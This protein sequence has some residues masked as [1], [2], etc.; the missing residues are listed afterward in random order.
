M[1]LSENAL[2]VLKARYLLKDENGEV[3]ESPTE[4]FRRVARSIAKMEKAYGEDARYWE[5]QFYDLMS[6]LRF[7]PNSPA[8]MNAGKSIGQLAACFALPVEDSM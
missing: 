1:E 6:S 4:M 7:L 5:E 3:I 8:I 2:R